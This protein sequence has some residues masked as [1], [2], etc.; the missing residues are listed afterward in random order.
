MKPRDDTL[1]RM[2]RAVRRVEHRLLTTTSA[3]EA[4]GIAYAVIWRQRGRVL[5]GDVVTE[6]QAVTVQ[7][8]TFDSEAR[9]IGLSLKSLK[10]EADGVVFEEEQAEADAEKAAS[11]ERAANRPFN[12]NLRGGIGGS[13]FTFG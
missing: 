7:V 11:A 10:A 4:A 8:L 3:L 5:G 9:K 6:G 13:H 2:F 1:E 12:P